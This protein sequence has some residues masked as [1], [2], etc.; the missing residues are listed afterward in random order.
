MID[1]GFDVFGALGQAGQMPAPEVDAGEQV[2]PETSGRDL[3][4]QIAIG[5]GDQ[6]EIAVHLVVTAHR[7]EASFLDGLEQHRLLVQ[8]QFADLVQKQHALMGA[9]QQTGPLACCTGEG[10]A[11]VA[12]QRAAGGVAAQGGA[13]DLDEASR[14]LV[15][16]FL[17]FK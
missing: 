1:V 4:A 7:Q 8:P 11:L 17:E 16:V 14:H 3:V 15:A 2:L 6:L 10:T 5:A 13:V 9:A 12:E